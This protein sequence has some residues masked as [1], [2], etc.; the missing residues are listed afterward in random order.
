MSIDAQLAQGSKLYIAGSST[1]PVVLTAI[2]VGF[3]TILAITGHTGVANGDVVTL[4]GFT[5]T[6]AADLNGKTFV[7]QNYATG[8]TNDTFAINVNT[9]GKTITINASSSTATGTAW[10]QIKQTK[11]IKPS[12]ATASKIDVTD[13]DS[14]AKEY[15]TGLVDNGTASVEIF[16]LESDPGQAAALAAFNASSVNS[17]KFVTPAKNRTFNASITKFPT[18]PDVAVDGVQTGSIEIVISGAITVS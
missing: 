13:L 12:N 4:A 11:S 3:P 9:V 17:Y 5:G 7:V 14:T 16:I 6:N 2:T 18:A 1:T 15:R 10:V 8:A